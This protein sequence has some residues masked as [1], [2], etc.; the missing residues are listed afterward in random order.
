MGARDDAE[1]FAAFVVDGSSD[2]KNAGVESIDFHDKVLVTIDQITDG[3]PSG[4]HTATFADLVVNLQTGDFHAIGPGLIESISPDKEGDLQGAPPVTARANSPAQTTE[5]AFVYMQ[6]EFIGELTGNKD[7]KE[8]ELTQ[9]VVAMVTP[10]RHVDEEIDLQIVSTED[11]PERAGILRAEVLNVSSIE[12][13]GQDPKDDT[14]SFSMIA[15]NNARLE[16]RDITARAD[17]IVYDHDK[18]QF[19]MKADGEGRVSVSHRSGPRGKYN[20]FN[21]KR[22]EYYRRTHELK[23]D[24][25]GGFEYPE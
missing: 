20:R 9:N 6:V 2:K 7:R 21:G 15:R 10:A 4:R 11:L 14:V 18:Q 5:T 1:G 3:I 13:P 23:G 17:E 19:I 25:I 24:R 16:S 12:K 22:C 8:A